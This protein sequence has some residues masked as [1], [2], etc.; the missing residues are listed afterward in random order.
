[1]S[2]RLKD[3]KSLSGKHTHDEH[4]TNNNLPNNY[5]ILKVELKTQNCKSFE[6]LEITKQKK[7]PKKLIN[8]ITV[9]LFTLVTVAL[10]VFQFVEFLFHCVGAC[11][12]P[13]KM[14]F[15]NE[16][17]IIISYLFC[18]VLYTKSQSLYTLPCVGSFY[19][20]FNVNTFFKWVPTSKSRVTY[21]LDTDTATHKIIG[22]SPI[23]LATPVSTTDIYK[24]SWIQGAPYN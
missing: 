21:D 3:D 6:E 22:V 17:Y 13:P 14:V 1:M 5:T 16:R 24:N 10:L 23:Y 15:E 9:V 20:F 11:H 8:N 18:T 7:H 19:Y 4:P 12:R 2:Q